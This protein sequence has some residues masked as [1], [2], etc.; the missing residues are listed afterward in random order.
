MEAKDDQGC[1][2]DDA[3]TTTTPWMEVFDP[4]KVVHELEE[5]LRD[6]DNP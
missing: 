6:V 2:S 1:E 5:K 4:E 3:I